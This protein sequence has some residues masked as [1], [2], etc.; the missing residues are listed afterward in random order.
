ML[1]MGPGMVYGWVPGIALPATLPPPLP[2]VHLPPTALAG[3][4]ASAPRA[5]Y[6]MVVGLK[7]VGQL[8][9]D[10]HFS[11]FK[12]ITEVYNL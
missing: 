7:S 10:V 2:R 5:R 1:N 4:A 11:G 3:T 9:L 6:N 8:T 12:G